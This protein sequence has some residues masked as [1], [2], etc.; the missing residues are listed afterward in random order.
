M[1]TVQMYGH[2]MQNLVRWEPT[3]YIYGSLYP[4]NKICPR[5][6]F[7]LFSASVVDSSI[8]PYDG[9]EV[10]DHIYIYIHNYD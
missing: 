9:I 2:T 6:F 4:L 1:Y 8:L 5:F 7:R 10:V 3:R